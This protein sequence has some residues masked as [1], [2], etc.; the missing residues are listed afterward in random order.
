MKAGDICPSCCEGMVELR[1]LPFPSVRRYLKC[2]YCHDIFP[3]TDR[4]PAS[5]CV[6]PGWWRTGK[7]ARLIFWISFIVIF[8]YLVLTSDYD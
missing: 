5:D 8:V 7:G 4:C 2:D 6:T 3:A 1:N